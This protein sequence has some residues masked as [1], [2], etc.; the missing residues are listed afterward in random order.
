MN[1]PFDACEFAPICPP[2]N[3][4]VRFYS[5]DDAENAGIAHSPYTWFHTVRLPEA[6]ANVAASNYLEGWERFSLRANY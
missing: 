4:A 2:I 1:N 6:M 3:P 5:I